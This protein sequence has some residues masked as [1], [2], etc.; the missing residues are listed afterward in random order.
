MENGAALSSLESFLFFVVPTFILAHSI[1]YN[2]SAEEY[3]YLNQH[4]SSCCAFS[5]TSCDL[6]SFDNFP[7]TIAVTTFI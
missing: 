7:L 1:L 4:F 2:R 6:P 5:P 3:W